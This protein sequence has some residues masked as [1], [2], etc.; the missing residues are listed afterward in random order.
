MNAQTAMV[1]TVLYNIT[2]RDH[3]HQMSMMKVIGFSFNRKPF[4]SHRR[5]LRFL[6]FIFILLY[7]H[8]C[9]CVYS[10]FV[11]LNEI[12]VYTLIFSYLNSLNQTVF[13]LRK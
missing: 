8:E 5:R 7:E 2:E 11:T 13:S 9:I 6:T 4:Q 1:F 10:K 3:T 12:L